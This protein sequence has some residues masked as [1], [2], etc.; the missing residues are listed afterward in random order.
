MV[1]VDIRD[2]EFLRAV[3]D[4]LRDLNTNYW[5]LN[6]PNGFHVVTRR[7]FTLDEKFKGMILA[8]YLLNHDGKLTDSERNAII[9]VVNTME[10]RPNQL[11]LVYFEY[12]D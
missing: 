2:K 9:E 8:K 7:T 1:D 12:E 10:T 6:T 5:V 11:G 4:V 3:E